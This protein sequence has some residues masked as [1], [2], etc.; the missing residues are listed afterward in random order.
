MDNWKN[1]YDI[2]KYFSTLKLPIKCIL[3]QLHGVRSIQ[4]S[5]A[6]HPCIISRT[7]ALITM[8]LHQHHLKWDSIISSNQPRDMMYLGCFLAAY[9]RILIGSYIFLIYTAKIVKPPPWKLSC[10]PY[11]AIW[12][13]INSGIAIKVYSINLSHLSNSYQILEV[14]KY[15]AN[16]HGPLFKSLTTLHLWM[17]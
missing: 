9:D 2:L 13:M 5:R 16:F 4:T 7:D 11:I 15:A 12:R 8:Q 17:W 14:V 10:S 3:N 1:I 6:R